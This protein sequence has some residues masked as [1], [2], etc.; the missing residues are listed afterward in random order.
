MRIARVKR[1]LGTGLVG[2]SS[3]LIF[4]HGLYFVDGLSEGA[5]NAFAPG[6]KLKPYLGPEGTIIFDGAR[7]KGDMMTTTINND[8]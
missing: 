2:K 6:E 4:R 5:F 8:R 1:R 3:G 7:P